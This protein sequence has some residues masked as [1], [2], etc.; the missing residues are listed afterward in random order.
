M[1]LRRFGKFTK[2]LSGLVELGLIFGGRLHAVL[3]T[4]QQALAASVYYSGHDWITPGLAARGKAASRKALAIKG[5][6]LRLLDF[7]FIQGDLPHR[8][9]DKFGFRFR[10]FILSHEHSDLMLDDDRRR[11]FYFSSKPVR[12]H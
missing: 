1:F 9:L 12:A 11:K 6:L 5:G 8:P 7:G 10:N 4:L 3:F 2:R